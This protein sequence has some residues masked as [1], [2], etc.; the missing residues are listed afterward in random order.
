MNWWALKR[1][2]D[3]GRLYLQHVHIFPDSVTPYVAAVIVIKEVAQNGPVFGSSIL[4]SSETRR[5]NVRTVWQQE[6]ILFWRP[7]A[8][9]IGWLM[10]LE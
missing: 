3:I 5:S 8:E 10:R 4:S 9:E 1:E 6:R 7:A 2:S